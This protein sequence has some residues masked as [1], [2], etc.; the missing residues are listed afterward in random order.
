MTGVTNILL[1]AFFGALGT[2]A[3]YG[4]AA[5]IQPLA[6]GRFP[7]ST[8]LVNVLGSLIMGVLYVL[9]LEKLWL[10]PEW[11]SFLMV[12][13]LGAFTTFSAFSLDTLALWQNGQPLLAVAYVVASLV[14]CLGGV[15]VAVAVTRL[16]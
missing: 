9:I 11:R 16:F 3:R 14:L 7:I 10:A 12:G 6:G 15:A 13:F 8:L 1:V 4:L 2:L 5:L